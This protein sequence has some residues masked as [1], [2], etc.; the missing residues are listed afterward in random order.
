MINKDKAN[1]E[2]IHDDLFLLIH[3]MGIQQT[4]IKCISSVIDSTLN[5]YVIQHEYIPMNIAKLTGQSKVSTLIFGGKRH[6]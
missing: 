6:T 5:Y 3:M 4:K 1:L 2:R